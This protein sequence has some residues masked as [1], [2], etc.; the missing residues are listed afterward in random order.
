MPA[1]VKDEARRIADNIL[2]LPGLRAQKIRHEEIAGQL[3]MYHT[4]QGED[5]SQAKQKATNDLR[6][7]VAQVV[8]RA[9]A[10]V[11]WSRGKT[12]FMQSLVLSQAWSLLRDAQQ[13]LEGEA[14][15]MD[16]TAG[17]HTESDGQQQLEKDKQK[18]V[19]KQKEAERA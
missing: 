2:N 17:G 10:E 7:R 3:A 13:R 4:R 14:F 15:W 18:E 12:R 5:I 11:R 6:D 1:L 19:D 16:I 8:V 9:A